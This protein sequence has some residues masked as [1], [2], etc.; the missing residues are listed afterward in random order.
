MSEQKTLPISNAPF[1]V[2][3]ELIDKNFLKGYCKSIK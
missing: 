2:N 1:I 3:P